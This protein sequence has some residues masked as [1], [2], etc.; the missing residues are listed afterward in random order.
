MKN[1]VIVTEI[2]SYPWCFYIKKIPVSKS[3]LVQRHMQ[4]YHYVTEATESFHKKLCFFSEPLKRQSLLSFQNV[5]HLTDSLSLS[6]MHGITIYLL[7][8][9]EARMPNT[10]THDGWHHGGITFDAAG[11]SGTKSY[12]KWN[13]CD[14][15]WGQKYSTW[16]VPVEFLLSFIQV[17]LPQNMY[18]CSVGTARRDDELSALTLK[19]AL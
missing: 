1:D 16:S 8:T 10:H 11:N 15:Q 12:L 4:H 18:V 17:P 5:A 19:C 2:T 9:D 14:I 3:W 6:K 7:L 13:I